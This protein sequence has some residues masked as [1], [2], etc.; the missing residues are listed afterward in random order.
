MALKDITRQAVLQAIREYDSDGRENFLKNNGFGYARTY[1]L[2]YDGRRYDSKAIIGVAHN[3]YARPGLKPLGRFVSGADTVQPVLENLNFTVL[4]GSAETDDIILPGEASAG[5]FDPLSIEDARERI[6]RMIAQ[7]RGQ[8][9]FRN[10]LLD[11]YDRK[12]A[13][14]GCEVVE[15]LQA[16]H[17]YPYR[18]PD[19]NKVVNGLLLRAD[20]HTLFDSGLIAVDVKNL[21][22]LVD[23]S[24]EGSEY[25][26]FHG[27]KL[28]LP[29]DTER[30]PSCEVLKMHCDNSVLGFSQ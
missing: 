25:W 2:I 17:I 30:R 22:V 5:P 4:V 16:A 12:C 7:R 29:S 21:T 27:Q 26:T 6:S 3:K 8:P 18:G 15:V 19:T 1:W 24:L 28:R 9:A 11:A 10:A 20:V 13:I 14:T 23:K